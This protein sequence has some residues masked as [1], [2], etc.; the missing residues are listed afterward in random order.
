MARWRVAAVAT[1][2]APHAVARA[3]RA[4]KALLILHCLGSILLATQRSDRLLL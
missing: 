3:R 2:T 1:A 4:T